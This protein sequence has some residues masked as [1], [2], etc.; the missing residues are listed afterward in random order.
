M[1]A[2]NVAGLP[3]SG[4]TAEQLRAVYRVMR[5]LA[6]D[7]RERGTPFTSTVVCA[8]CRRQRPAVGSVD[9]HGTRLCNGCAT[10][11]EVLRMASV[12]DDVEGFL[13]RPAAITPGG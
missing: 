8:A 9:Y 4:A 3:R 5:I 2:T 1:V 10:E 7:D 13:A 11:Y 6:D 12:V